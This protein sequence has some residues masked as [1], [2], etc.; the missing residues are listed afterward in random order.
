MDLV[1]K[2]AAGCWV[3]S[4]GTLPFV[5]LEFSSHFAFASRRCALQRVVDAL[6]ALRVAVKAI[7]VAV[8]FVESFAFASLAFAVGAGVVE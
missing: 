3:F 7:V 1:I 5:L 4:Q 8:A 6:I 2:F